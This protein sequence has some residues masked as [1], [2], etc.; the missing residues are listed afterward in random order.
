MGRGDL[1]DTE[2]QRLQSLLPADN[3]R[4]GR[5]R[6]HR[7][8]IDGIL[9]RVRTGVQWRDPPND[10]GRGR[11]T[12]NVTGFGQPTAPGSDCSS[13]SR[14]W[15]KRQASSAGTSR[16]T[17]QSSA[18]H[19]C[20]TARAEP[21]RPPSSQKGTQ[22]RSGRTPTRDAVAESRP[23]GGGGAG[24]EGMGRSR[25][26]FTTTLH[27]NADGRCH[28]LSVIVTP[29]HR[30][31]CMPFIAVMEKIRVPRLGTREPVRSQCGPCVTQISCAA[32]SRRPRWPRRC[33]RPSPSASRAGRASRRRSRAWG[34]RSA[35]TSG[36]SSR[37]RRS[38]SSVRG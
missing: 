18:H 20:A 35:C 14:P 4:C 21:P 11:R 33:R 36:R 24:G 29:G 5:W 25:G 8:V 28:P 30:A 37:W 34:P 10:S 9:H 27:L 3:G 7:Q 22:P 38:G 19:H 32:T 2:W 16:W 12:T 15:P 23:P 1:P 13:R 26:G 31:D 17:P 6:D